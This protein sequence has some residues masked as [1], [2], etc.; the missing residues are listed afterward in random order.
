M[1]GLAVFCSVFVTQVVAQEKCEEITLKTIQSH[2]PSPLPINTKI[3]SQ[4]ELKGLCEI[5]IKADGKKLPIY[6]NTE[7]NFIIV[8][9]MFSVKR[10]LSSEQIEEIHGKEFLALKKE[11]NRATA[12]T[13]NHSANSEHTIYMFTDPACPWCHKAESQ[14]KKIAD[15]YN[16]ILKVIFYPI[17]IQGKEKAIVAVCHKFNLINY[18][19]EEW[20]K[21]KIND[22]QCQEGKVLINDSIILGRK[23][24]ISGV[25]TFYLENGKK[26]IGANMT[27][28]KNELTKL[29]SKNEK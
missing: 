25:P 19:K 24:S 10:N 23:L 3:I 20:R 26:I 9:Q 8:G 6:F 1:V 28:L 27:E 21:Q 14:I 13:Y 2:L 5:I 11:I 29:I 16:L 7:E 22:Y 17:N 12:I 15:E 18:L 4:R